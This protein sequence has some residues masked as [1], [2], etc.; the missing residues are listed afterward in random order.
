MRLLQQS[1]LDAGWSDEMWAREMDA[2]DAAAASQN[3]SVERLSSHLLLH[4]H[5]YLS[6]LLLSCF[7]LALA[8]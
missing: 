7:T 5:L 2:P 8:R 4:P 6:T 1:L 3:S